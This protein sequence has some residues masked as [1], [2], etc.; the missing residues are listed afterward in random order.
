M[1]FEQILTDAIQWMRELTLEQVQTGIVSP[2]FNEGWCGITLLYF[3]VCLLLLAYRAAPLWF[4][5]RRVTKP[6]RKVNGPEAFAQQFESYQQTVRSVKRLRHAWQEFAESLILPREGE[7]LRVRNTQEPSAYFNDATV[8]QPIIHN[9]FFDTVPSH[10]VGLGILGTFL[11]LAA[12]VGLASSGLKAEDPKQVQEALSTLL[13]GASLAFV[14]SIFGLGSSIVFLFLERTSVGSVHRS[15]DR[16]VSRLEACVELVTPEQIALEQLEQEKRQTKQLENFS[17]QLVFSLE[18]AFDSVAA[19]RLAPSLEKVVHAIE[20]LRVDRADTNQA[21]IERLVREFLDKLSQSTG[22]EMQ[23]IQTTLQTLGGRL[24]EVTESLR[25]ASRGF[26]EQIAGAGAQIQASGRT[27]AEGLVMSI[28]PFGEAIERF[29]RATTG[30][31]ELA[32]RVEGMTNG[33]RAAAETLLEAHRGF[34]ASLEPSRAVAASLEATG[35]RLAGAVEEARRLTE[36]ASGTANAITAEQEKIS[37]AWQDYERRFQDVDQALLR[38]FEQIDLGLQ[39]YAE[40]VRQFHL[41]IDQ[42]MSKAIQMLAAHTAELVDAVEDLGEKM[43]AGR[44]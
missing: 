10:L 24:T 21:G 40:K 37:A 25:E 42:Q 9:R 30:Q 34:Q 43:S 35:S 22:Q 1:P 33:L 14:T 6:L 16:W 38:A 18:Q 3:L 31:A 19:E 15:L 41:E 8:V 17:D 39:A 29:E 27:T 11:G 5:L 12:G 26:G 23:Q 4:S 36:Q 28:R 13:S 2:G 7:P 20:G 32:T 44:G